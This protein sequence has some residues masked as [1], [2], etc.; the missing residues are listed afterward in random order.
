MK[1]YISLVETEALVFQKILKVPENRLQIERAQKTLSVSLV[2]NEEYLIRDG[3]FIIILSSAVDAFEIP[4]KEENL[5]LNHFKIPAGKVLLKDRQVRED[6]T[7]E[8]D[9]A[10]EEQKDSEEIN[11]LPLRNGL[12]SV[13]SVIQTNDAYSQEGL[14]IINGF[15]DFSEFK[16][17]FIS[18]VIK[19]GFFPLKRLNLEEFKPDYFF[20]F[21]WWFHF[22]MENLVSK[23]SGKNDEELIKTHKAWFAGFVDHQDISTIS[24]ALQKTPAIVKEDINFLFG[25]Y[26]ATM[27]FEAAEKEDLLT[28]FEGCLFD[29][30][31]ERKEEV[32]MWAVFFHSLFREDLIYRY[33][34]N[35]LQQEVFKAEK[36]AF[37]FVNN[38]LTENLVVKKV[39]LQKEEQI[40]PFLELIRGEV[41][42]SP[43]VTS[44]SGLRSIFFNKLFRENLDKVGLEPSSTLT[45]LAVPNRATLSRGVFKME[46]VS[47]PSEVSFYVST[48]S[49]ITTY[50][51]D[52]K[53]KLKPLN[54]LIDKKKKILVGF[55]E[56][57]N[58]GLL[59]TYGHILQTLDEKPF[60]RFVL[61]WL[62]DR[63][64]E[65][66]HSTAFDLERKEVESKFIQLLGLNTQILIKNK[67]NKKDEEIKRNLKN[68]LS[69]YST[70]QLEVV[71]ENFDDEKARW[72]VERNSEFFVEDH[73]DN[74]YYYFQ[75]N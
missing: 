23:R 38:F 19:E 36:L 67:R 49:E 17:H 18:E 60:E 35:S 1:I 66:I 29:I 3:N 47:V 43:S 69:E 14:E 15:S 10:D 9:F 48:E 63:E 55:L 27:T 45:N 34:I 12:I 26:L 64:Q 41:K 28:H 13:L 71:D 42:A 7:D 22:I 58:S 24:Q 16:K 52:L 2:L 37:N 73:P 25:Y 39:Q 51:R 68:I 70:N 32:L 30:E 11:Y 5:F 62:I 75:N 56:G 40:S 61:V 33:F 46:L 31:L 50:L 20:R 6:P 8:F 65:E 74:Q 57:K 72:L 59:N 54:K 4:E 21:I 44:P 53:I